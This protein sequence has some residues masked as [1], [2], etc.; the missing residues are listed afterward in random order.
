MLDHFQ[1]LN[2]S[3]SFSPHYLKDLEAGD[4]ED[5]DEVLTRQSGGQGRVDSTN[6]PPEHPVVG[7]F[8]Q[9]CDGVVHLHT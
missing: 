9:R 8:G 7:G 1:I 4:V 6:Q 5:A 3:N 2:L